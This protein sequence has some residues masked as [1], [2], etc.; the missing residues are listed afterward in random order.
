L[1]VGTGG[2]WK[3]IIAA[4]ATALVVSSFGVVR[5]YAPIADADAPGGPP[6]PLALGFSV[7][8]PLLVLFFDWVS[9]QMGSP[10]KAAMT[11]AISQLL[12]VDVDYVLSGKRGV[13]AGSASALL[14]LVNWSLI[15]AVY[16]KLL[17]Y[18]SPSR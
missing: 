10:M 5:F 9:R 7:S 8:I 14:L 2:R 11:V 16:G 12:L 17:N 6:V 3:P 15:G 4:L 1:E 18:N 13:A